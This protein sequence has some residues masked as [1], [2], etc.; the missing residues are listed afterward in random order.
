MLFELKDRGINN[1][2]PEFVTSSDD[3][4]PPCSIRRPVIP[5]IGISVLHPT[6]LNKKGRVLNKNKLLSARIL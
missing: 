3:F 4:T 6:S 2:Y 5:F 1:E